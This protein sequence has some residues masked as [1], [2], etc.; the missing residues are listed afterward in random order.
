VGKGGDGK[1]ARGRRAS[2]TLAR[3]GRHPWLPG[4]AFF[5]SVLALGAVGFG[6]GSRSLVP[7]EHS[8]TVLSRAYAYDPPVIRVNKG[9]TLRLR[10]A[11][12]DVVH[13]FYLEG[14]DL[15]VT[16]VPMRSQ[17]E[18]RH[19]SRPGE[20]ESVEEV[21]IKADREGKYRYRC[22]HTCGF[23]HP[24]MLGELIVEPNRLLPTGIGMTLG[25]LLGGFLFVTLRPEE[26]Q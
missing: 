15:D 5:V 8:I 20:R 25:V 11:S 9:D 26:R 6:L 17:V 24:F 10:L 3:L 4:A 23:L 22:S 1:T 19:P 2:E 7:Q 12:L 13:G 14:H 18:V 21:V 16:V